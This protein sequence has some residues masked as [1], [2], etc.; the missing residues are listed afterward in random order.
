MPRLVFFFIFFVLSCT[1][2]HMHASMHDVQFNE[3]CIKFE[4]KEKE[5]K[6]GGQGGRQERKGRKQQLVTLHSTTAIENTFIIHL[7]MLL[8]CTCIHSWFMCIFLVILGGTNKVHGNG[9]YNNLSLWAFQQHCRRRT[10][11]CWELLACYCYVLYLVKGF[12][13]WLLL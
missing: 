12:W 10:N 3:Y 6:F 11:C 8:V 13:L 1:C 4:K 5:K 2:M 7:S 9:A